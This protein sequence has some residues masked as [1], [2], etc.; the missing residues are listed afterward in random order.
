[1]NTNC[2]TVCTEQM[3]CT[4]CT[5]LVGLLMDWRGSALLINLFLLYRI[6]YI[7]LHTL[8]INDLDVYATDDNECQQ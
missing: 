8:K 4:L 6:V 7:T 3:L 5:L 1:M 2:R